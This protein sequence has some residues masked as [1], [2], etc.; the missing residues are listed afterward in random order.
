MN[1]EIYQSIILEHF[2]EPRCRQFLDENDP[3][4]V[5]IRNPNCG[6]LV[7]LRLELQSDGN[8]VWVNDAQGCA[9]SVASTSIFCEHLTG[10]QVEVVAEKISEFLKLLADGTS[11][12]PDAPTNDMEIDALLYFRNVPA[13]KLCVSLAWTCAENALARYL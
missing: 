11:V 12:N 1:R 3:D 9:A 4:V 6:D 10:L 7:K 8:C 13:R 5:V 2:R